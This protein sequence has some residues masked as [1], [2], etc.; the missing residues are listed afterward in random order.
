MAKKV[1]NRW[2]DYAT[3][4][5]ED[6]EAIVLADQVAVDREHAWVARQLE[7]RRSVI[8]DSH[9]SPFHIEASRPMAE[10]V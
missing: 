6:Q 8:S 10:R 3:F 1:R 7:Q 5:A 4:L 9:W 2:A